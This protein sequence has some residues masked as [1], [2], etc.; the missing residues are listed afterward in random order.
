[1][2]AMRL[3]RGGAALFFFSLFT[4]CSIIKTF[5]SFF[6]FAYPGVPAEILGT[7]EFMTDQGHEDLATAYGLNDDSEGSE[8]QWFTAKT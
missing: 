7:D 3:C 1:M 8:R 4:S 2:K 6:L 5:F